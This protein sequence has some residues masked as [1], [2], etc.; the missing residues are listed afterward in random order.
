[1][2]GTLETTSRQH[3]ATAT[4]AAKSVEDLWARFVATRSRQARDQLVVQYAPLV[5]YVVGRL[6][7]SLPAVLDSDDVLSYGIIG[8]MHA[9]SR[10]DPD[11]GIK[12]ESYAVPRIRGAI[13]DALRSL[14]PVSRTARDHARDIEQVVVALQSQLGRPPTDHEVAQSLGV[15]V[16]RYHQQCVQGAV[17]VLSLD[18]LLDADG[19]PS[20]S[21]HRDFLEDK[22]MPAPPDVVERRELLQRLREMVARLPERERIVLALYYND[23][24]TMKEISRVMDISES[25]V[26]QLHAQAILR[27]RGRLLDDV[28]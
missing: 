11:R 4:C 1:M 10:F 3:T 12:F 26:C 15:S 13:V 2:I 25:R 8:L 22:S 21:G 5:K 6:A 23:G 18:N 28:G 16:D 27:L 9:I 20:S 14:D 7:I 17:T 19:D 24:L